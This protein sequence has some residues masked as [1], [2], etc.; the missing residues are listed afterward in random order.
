MPD[1]IVSPSNYAVFELLIGDDCLM[2]NSRIVILSWL[3]SLAF[4]FSSFAVVTAQQSRSARHRGNSSPARDARPRLV[5]LIVVDQFRYDYLNRFGD[6]FGSRGIGRLMRDG[7][8]WTETNFDQVPTFTAP[9]HAVFMTGAW[10]SQ[11]GIVANEWYERDTG[12]KVKSVTD[13]STI[14]LAGKPGEKGFSPR[15]LLCSTVGDELRIADRDQSKVIGI[16][17]KDRSAILPVGRRAN[18][19]YW[20]GTDN[21]NMVSSTYYFKQEPEWVDR[22]NSRH[23]ADK[24]FGARW[25]RLLPEA[26]YL[27]RAGKDDVP[28]E[29]LDKSSADTNF[30][31]HVITGGVS[32]PEREFYKAIDYTPFSNDLLVS[33][34]EEAITNEKLGEDAETDVLSVS[35]SA[36]D[37]AGHRFGPY[38]QEAMDMTLRVDRQ[39]GTLLDFV[40]ARV[41]LQNTV[42]VF[43]SDHGASPVPEQAALMNLPGRRYQK[44]ELRKRVEDGL[45]AKYARQDRPAVDYL[46]KFTN[47][48]EIE[49]GLINANFYLNR[50]ALERDGIDLDECERVVGELSL[51]MPGAARYF[52]RAQLQNNLL[53]ASDPIARRVLNGFYSQ[54]SGDVIVIFEPYSI[55]F[56]LP[57]DPTDPLSSATHGSPYSYD[58]HVPLIIMGRDFVKG[59]YSQPATPADIAPTLSNLLRIQRPSCSVG[60]VLSEALKSPGQR[61]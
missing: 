31:P 60:R 30:F 41:G 59:V 2:K 14:K 49:E 44:A 34:A 1:R 21:G 47:R 10:P 35:F 23:L 12:R 48:N 40:D 3:L 32:R 45:R 56:D 13:D 24:L 15:R 50:A 53:S 8:S 33:F 20:F 5:L 9:G 58:T 37:Y 26:E 51:Q 6:L 42:V 11:T 39:I 16:S 25:E 29:N 7:A 4:V 52:T 54:R 55:L 18:A 19:A 22:F 27:K 57:D 28:W 36:N 17:A 46:Q 61:Y 38:S 43:T